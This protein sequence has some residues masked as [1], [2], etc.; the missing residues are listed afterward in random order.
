MHFMNSVY[1]VMRSKILFE[2]EAGEIFVKYS[3]KTS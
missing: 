1:F 3:I 2:N